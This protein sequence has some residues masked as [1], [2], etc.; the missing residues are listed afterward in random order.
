MILVVSTSNATGSKLAKVGNKKKSHGDSSCFYLKRSARGVCDIW[1]HS[2]FR[3]TATTHPHDLAYQADVTRTFDESPEE[4]KDPRECLEE[5][6]VKLVQ[7]TDSVLWRGGGRLEEG[8]GGKRV[9]ATVDNVLW[10]GVLNGSK[11]HIVS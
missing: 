9:L 6:G 1:I 3:V 5:G 7:A 8:G 10:R 2:F 4:E 11:P